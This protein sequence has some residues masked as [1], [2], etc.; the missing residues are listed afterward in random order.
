MPSL[1][2]KKGTFFLKYFLTFSAIIL[3]SFLII[4]IALMAFVT[5]FLRS[6][7]L[8]ELS[9]DAKSI[10]SMTSEL[11]ISQAANRNP[12]G[13]AMMLY[14][15]LSIMSDCTES[16][17]FICNKYGNVIACKDIMKNTFELSGNTVCD[18]HSEIK[19][20]S[21]VIER[22]KDGDFSELTRLDGVYTKLHAVAL[23]PIYLYDE[24]SGFTI[25]ASPLS[26]EIKDYG[27]K[28]LTMFLLAAAI[29]LILATVA[30]YFLT[31]R[32]TKPI[33]QL[34]AATRCYASGDFSYKV[35]ELNTNDELS[36]LI[37]EFNAMGVA[38]SKLENSRRSFVANVSHEFKTP[39]TTIGGFING[40]LDGTIPP[41]KQNYYLEIVASEVKRLSKMVNMMLNISKIETGNIDMNIEQF[42]ISGK[43]VST[44]LG[45]EQLVSKK[46]I[47]I[48][49][50]EDLSSA[51][52]HADSAMIDQVV[53]NLIDNAVKFTNE[54]G[55]IL[56]N[57]ASDERF[58]YFSI[59]NS[60]KGI[61]RDDLKRVFD[62]FYKV[63]ASRSTD[64]KST[65]LGLYLVKSI[66]DLH[67]GTITVDSE[68]DNFT[69]FTVK[70]PK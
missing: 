69:R 57:T 1:N 10:S 68:P 4:G 20:P 22:A 6:H 55:K 30:L 47:E 34:A 64:V 2:N 28:I 62:R 35:P 7:T 46:K 23:E 21:S 12:E 42:D 8:N 36:E 56:I 16:D 43:L 59:T 60:G 9:D 44:I 19:I 53:Y 25:T 39:M 11:V 66:V 40:I 63:D 51:T 32:F 49:G 26:G 70:L 24:F 41:E 50:L 61:P 5:T 65:G 48:Y 58:S 13:A 54:N 45:F 31:D 29:T 3:V 17:V 38:L 27:S 15:T 33:R 14:K 18:Y 37:T 67:G 52:V